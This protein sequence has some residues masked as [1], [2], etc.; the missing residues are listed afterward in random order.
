MIHLGHK[1]N[2]IT[3]FIFSIQLPK[4]E[5][6]WRGNWP[7]C[8]TVFFISDSRVLVSWTLIHPLWSRTFSAFL[9]NFNFFLTLFPLL[10]RANNSCETSNSI[11]FGGGFLLYVNSNWSWMNFYGHW[12]FV[13]SILLSLV[14]VQFYLTKYNFPV[15]LDSFNTYW[16]TIANV[17][18]DN[19]EN[20]TEIFTYKNSRADCCMKI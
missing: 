6:I 14:K 20:T 15:S 11:V 7:Y 13:F 1:D 17:T 10:K 2:Q 4:K 9:K 12:R 18:M 19:L 8:F 5:S 3:F 16:N